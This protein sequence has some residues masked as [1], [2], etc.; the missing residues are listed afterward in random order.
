[1][2]K[3]WRGFFFNDEIILSILATL[4]LFEDARVLPVK[5]ISSHNTSEETYIKYSDEH[6][7]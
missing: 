7:F 6:F 3:G 1:M 2:V 4:L 5:F